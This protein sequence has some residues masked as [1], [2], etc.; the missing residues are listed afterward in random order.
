MHASDRALRRGVESQA[1]YVCAGIGAEVLHSR[2]YGKYST[3]DEE[4]L[5]LNHLAVSYGCT[6]LRWYLEEQYL[7]R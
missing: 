3:T 4:D 6:E 2:R 1:L 7:M 5:I